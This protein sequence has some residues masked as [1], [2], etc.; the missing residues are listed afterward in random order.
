MA[1]L[2]N[3]MLRAKFTKQF[4]D[5][6]PYLDEILFENFDAPSLTYPSAFNVQDSSRAFEEKTGIAGF[7]QFPEKSEGS[8]VEYDTLLQG[9][10]V[11]FTHKTFAKGFQISTEA[12]DDDIDGAIT[13][14]APALSRVARNSI[15]T[16]IWAD[17]NLGFTT[18]NSWDGVSLFNASHPHVGGGTFSNLVSADLSQGSIETAINIFDDFRD[19]RNQ[20]IEVEPAMLIY[21]PKLRWLVHEL[22]KSQL[23]S[24][25]ALNTANA[26]NQLSLQPLMTKYLT[27]ATDWFIISPAS[28]HRM[29][30]YWRQEP[31]SDHTLDFDTGNMKTKMT[32]RLSHGPADYRGLVGGDGT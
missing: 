1:S 17:Y 6:L 31:V 12:M 26:L 3:V 29:M 9:F 10:D 16:E 23:R 25:T 2:G 4:V 11:R 32:Y 18:L 30:V 15:E 28:Q 21:P 14:A 7:G 27:S 8:A 24:D 22:F 19:D 13:D 5:R 20:L